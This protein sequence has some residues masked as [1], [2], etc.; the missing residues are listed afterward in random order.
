MDHS[1]FKK[2]KTNNDKT[3][4]LMHCINRFDT[5]IES[6]SSRDNKLFDKRV[7]YCKKNLEMCM[8]NYDMN[9]R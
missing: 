9:K 7:D 5:C 8:K 1:I 2:K 6:F 4:R 3:I